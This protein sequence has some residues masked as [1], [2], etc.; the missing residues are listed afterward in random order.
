MADSI[1]T[2]PLSPVPSDLANTVIWDDKEDDEN[3]TLFI[4]ANGNRDTVMEN[5]ISSSSSKAPSQKVYNRR[6]LRETLEFIE[7]LY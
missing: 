7:G 2:S 6:R 4:N 1:L 5:A 3:S